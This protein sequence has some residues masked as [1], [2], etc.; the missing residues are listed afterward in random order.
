MRDANEIV[1]QEPSSSSKASSSVITRGA[2]NGNNR[3][4]A[5]VSTGEIYFGIRRR[6]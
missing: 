2:N 4:P 1:N 3:V 5:D 6:V